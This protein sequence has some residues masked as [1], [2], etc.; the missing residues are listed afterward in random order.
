[1]IVVIICSV[2]QLS[3]RH[4]SIYTIKSI[5]T[6]STPLSIAIDFQQSFV[7][8]ISVNETNLTFIWVVPYSGWFWNNNNTMTQWILMFISSK[9]KIYISEIVIHMFFSFLFQSAFIF[10]CLLTYLIL[11]VQKEMLAMQSLASFK[12]LFL[13]SPPKMTTT[14]L[15]DKTYDKT[16]L[17]H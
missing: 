10:S 9:S 11:M 16:Q 6:H 17:G 5:I 8:M 1:M 13:P 4:L 12:H 14:F 3:A 7:R 15:C 2:A